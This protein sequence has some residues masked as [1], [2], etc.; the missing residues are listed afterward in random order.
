MLLLLYNKDARTHAPPCSSVRR[1]ISAV[2][3]FFLRR[4]KIFFI[5]RYYSSSSIFYTY[6]TILYTADA[7]AHSAGSSWLSLFTSSLTRPVDFASY[8]LTIAS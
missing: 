6:L 4:L 3:F 2:S 7:S 8:T 1:G 5:W